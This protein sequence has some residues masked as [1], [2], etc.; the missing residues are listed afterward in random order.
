MSVYTFEAPE[1]GSGAG[2]NSDRLGEKKKNSDRLGEKRE[3]KVRGRTDSVRM[4]KRG[5]FALVMQAMINIKREKK[6]YCGMNGTMALVWHRLYCRCPG[7]LL[8]ISSL[9]LKYVC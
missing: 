5:L 3:K 9:H 7:P 1:E 4:K 8:L 2:K 6:M